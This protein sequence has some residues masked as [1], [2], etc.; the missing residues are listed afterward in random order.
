MPYFQKS[1][2][3]IDSC[4]FCHPPDKGRILFET[5][6]FYIMLSLGPVTE[7]YLLINSKIHYDSIGDE[8]DDLVERVRQIQARAYGACIFYEHGRAGSCLQYSEPSLHCYHAHLHCV[9]VNFDINHLIRNT[10]P[11]VFVNSYK[12]FRA[13]YQQ[14]EK[15][16]LFVHDRQMKIHFISQDIR[17]QYLRYLVSSQLGQEHLWDWTKYERREIIHSARKKLQPYF[18]AIS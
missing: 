2:E 7:G 5:R 15:P 17:K 11:T 14:C 3:G 18:D 12:E 1:F 9:P 10:T 4:R 16:Y 13:A 8:F 6:H